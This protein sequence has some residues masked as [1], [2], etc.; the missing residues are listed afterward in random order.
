MSSRRIAASSVASIRVSIGSYHSRNVLSK[1]CL[2]P[3][4]LSSPPSGVFLVA[5]QYT[6]FDPQ[7][8]IPKDMPLPHDSTKSPGGSSSC[9]RL[10]MPRQPVNPAYLGFLSPNKEDLTN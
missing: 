10:A 4:G 3:R 9:S 8:A 7:W 1:A 6:C 2:D 5:N